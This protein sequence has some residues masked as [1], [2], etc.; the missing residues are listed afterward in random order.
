[1]IRIT[2]R[3]DRIDLELCPFQVLTLGLRRTDS[4]STWQG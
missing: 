2:L 3:Q 4:V 1:M